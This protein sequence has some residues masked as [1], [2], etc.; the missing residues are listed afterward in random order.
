MCGHFRIR[1]K[2]HAMKEDTLV[3][4]LNWMQQITAI[5]QELCVQ[6]GMPFHADTLSAN[7]RELYDALMNESITEPTEG[8]T[9]R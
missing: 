8:K 9:T 4:F 7:A 5:T 3:A 6:K 1:G 2:G